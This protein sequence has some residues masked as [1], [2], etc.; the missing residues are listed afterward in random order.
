VTDFRTSAEEEAEAAEMLEGD[1]GPADAGWDA[2][3]DDAAAMDAAGSGNPG[4]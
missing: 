3:G 2:R 1:D 4:L